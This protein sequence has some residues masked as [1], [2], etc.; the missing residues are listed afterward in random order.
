[1]R[2]ALTERPDGVGDAVY[3]MECMHVY[4][5]KEGHKSDV[6]IR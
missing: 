1:M 4:N 3:V 2:P 5:M 6:I